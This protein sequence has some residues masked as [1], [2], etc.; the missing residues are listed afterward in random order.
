MD[1]WFPMYF[2]HVFA[3]WAFSVLQESR[4]NKHLDAFEVLAQSFFSPERA[5]MHPN[6][7]PRT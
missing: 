3:F 6:L 4:T 5:F 7:K 1:A 2:I